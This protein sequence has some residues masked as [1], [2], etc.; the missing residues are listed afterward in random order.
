MANISLWSQSSLSLL[1]RS[2]SLRYE[3]LVR[4]LSLQKRTSDRFLSSQFQ[5]LG[6]CLPLSQYATLT[7]NIPAEAC[8][9]SMAQSK[10]RSPP[11]YV[12]TGGLSGS[13]AE[14]RARPNEHHDGR[15]CGLRHIDVQ[16]RYD[17][18]SQEVQD[19]ERIVDVLRRLSGHIERVSPSP[20]A[21]DGGCVFITPRPPIS[22]VGFERD[23]LGRESS[24][25]GTRCHVCKPHQ[26]FGGEDQ[27]YH[28]VL[29]TGA[30]GE[31]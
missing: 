5:T 6:T 9:T 20:S 28:H 31:H 21:S 10:K 17:L 11:G 22:C 2:Q 18:F 14:I 24:A 16:E 30:V 26:Q 7:V 25:V 13:R 15:L 3:S 8:H 19:N 23:Q 4:F 29:I 27:L 12:L 1:L